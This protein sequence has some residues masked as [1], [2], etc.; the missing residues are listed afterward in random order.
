MQLSTVE[1]GIKKI[2]SN[3]DLT[4]RILGLS[5]L[6]FEIG[7]YRSPSEARSLLFRMTR[8]CPW[9]RCGFCGTYRAGKFEVRPVK[10]LK[11]DIDNMKT[12]DSVILDVSHALGFEGGVNDV[13]LNVIQN[14]NPLYYGNESYRMISHWRLY[15]QMTGFLQ[16]A[17]S[18]M[19]KPDDFIEAVRYLRK[20]MPDITRL[21][22]Y[23]RSQTVYSR[24]NH[25]SEISPWLDRLHI[26]LETGDPEL[27]RLI[28]KVGK[29]QP[30]DVQILAGQRAKAA[31]F[32]VSEY[33][34]PGLGG[35]EK[36]EDN[37]RNT[38]E[39]I[40]EINPH[41]VR[42]RPYSSAGGCPGTPH[43]LEFK[44]GRLTDT[45]NNGKLRE[46]EILVENLD[47]RFDGNLVFDI[48]SA[49]YA[50]STGKE[51]FRFSYEGFKFPEQKEHVLAHLRDGMKASEDQHKKIQSSSL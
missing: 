35:I 42:L 51:L 25:L 40:N 46:I 44:E 45:T 23:A 49:R 16:D 15:E 24:K 38:A 43:T 39:A 20:S 9:N 17:D 19:M 31:G 2:R 22:T 33:Y 6:S 4:D 28:H 32:E 21:T 7:N 26:G 37:A 29:K 36:M 34:M 8:N 11:A 41:Y 13:L 1:D 47:D 30:D 48:Q 14:I 5:K 12:I 27:L 50:N 18:M 3:R 10:E